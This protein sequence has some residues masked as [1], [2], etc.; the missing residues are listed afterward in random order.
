MR[1]SELTPG[2]KVFLARRRASM[3][4]Q[5]AARR[6]R[7]SLYTYRKWEKDEEKPEVSLPNLRSL[8]LFEKCLIKRRRSGYDAIEIAA[9][10]GICKWW[11]TQMEQGE[12]NVTRLAEYWGLA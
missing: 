4:Q 8:E 3:T 1:V 6:H 9:E 2:E 11:M 5:E 10:M 7:V 12:A